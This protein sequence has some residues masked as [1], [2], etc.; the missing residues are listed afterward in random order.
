MMVTRGWP[1][2]G[3]LFKWLCELELYEPVMTFRVGKGV[4]KRVNNISS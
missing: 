1:S 4:L 3:E 2:K